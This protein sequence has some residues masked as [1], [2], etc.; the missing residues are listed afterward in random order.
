MKRIAFLLVAVAIVVGVHA[1]EFPE[2]T[3]CLNG[4]RSRERHLHNA[5]P[6]SFD[7]RLRMTP[8]F[9]S[10]QSAF[11]VALLLF[12]GL[13]WTRPAVAQ[14]ADAWTARAKEG[15]FTASH[16]LFN[17]GETLPALHLHYRTL[18]SP[19]RGPD[20]HIDNAVLLL[21]GTGGSSKSFLI[22]TFADALFGPGQPL[23]IHRYYLI[24]PDD[25]GHGESSKPSDGLHMHF[26]RYD[27]DDMVRGQH[28]LVQDGLHVDHLRLIFGTSMGCMHTFLWGVTYPGYTDALAS[29]ACLTVPIAGRNLMWRSTAMEDIR[30]D[31][32]WHGGEYKSEPVAG[33]R[34]ESTLFLIATSSALQLQKQYPTRQQTQNYTDQYLGQSVHSIDA[35][36]CLYYLDASRSYDPSAQLGRIT[37]PV[38]WVNSADD[39]INPP[40]LGI[41]QQEARRMPNARFVLLPLTP[42]THGHLT[43]NYA[44]VWQQ[45]LG[46]LL[47]R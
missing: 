24:F 25:I 41:A 11:R 46:E 4:R 27:Y 40:D 18:G 38:L 20:G 21:H 12:A 30:N 8:H 14:T 22:P 42:E 3:K 17:D 45:Y 39:F 5:H 37:V 47:K 19:H 43:F 28:L 1:L 33:L 26:P 13:L 44:A 2:P 10:V 7:W 6:T 9:L 16:F 35:N 36:D 31:P 15:T 32:A 23:D 29:F 34:A